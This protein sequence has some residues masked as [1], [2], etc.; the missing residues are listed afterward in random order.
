MVQEQS[1]PAEHEKAVEVSAEVATKPKKLK[2][3]T[4]WSR[5]SNVTELS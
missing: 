5:Q 1:A 4:S 3:I 2:A